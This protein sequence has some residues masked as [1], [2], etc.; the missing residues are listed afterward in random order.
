MQAKNGE[1]PS[2]LQYSNRNQNHFNAVHQSSG[3]PSLRDVKG[4]QI[5]Q[6]HANAMD[7]DRVHSKTQ[8]Q[9]LSSSTARQLM[10]C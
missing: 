10:A 1:V 9:H 4:Q 3:S 2:S 6:R 8:L 5:Q 7:V